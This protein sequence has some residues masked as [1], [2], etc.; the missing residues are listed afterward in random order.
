MKKKLLF[1]AFPLL[2]LQLK[3]QT[4]YDFGSANQ[5]TIAPLYASGSTDVKH[6]HHR[7]RQ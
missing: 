1:M 3:A 6:S 5:A 4:T 7:G 2:F